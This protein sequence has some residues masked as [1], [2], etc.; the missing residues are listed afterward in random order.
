MRAREDA[1]RTGPLEVQSLY[2]IGALARAAN[3]SPYLLRRLLRAKGVELLRAGR[4]QLVPL[5]E[6]ETKIPLL[7]QSIQA[8]EMLRQ[9][10][11]E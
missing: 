8:A 7:W 2:S 11:E 1:G 9:G 3:V 10:I 6:L 5:V 4:A